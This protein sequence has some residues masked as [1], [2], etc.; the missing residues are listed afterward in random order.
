MIPLLVFLV[1]LLVAASSTPD[2]ELLSISSTTAKTYHPDNPP[3]LTID[4]DPNT[5]YHTIYGTE[6]PEPPQWL[7]LQLEEPALV[8][9]VVIVNR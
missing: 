5:F 2:G 9:R 3:E 6:T 1:K 7:K 4:G 8:S